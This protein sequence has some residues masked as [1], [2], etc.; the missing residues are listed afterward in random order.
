MRRLMVFSCLCAM[1]VMLLP[2]APAT[3]Q[4]QPGAFTP[5]DCFTELPAGMTTDDVRCGLVTVPLEH[6]D[7]EGE[8]I[9][10]AVVVVEATGSSPAADP[11]LMLGGG[12][13]EK[14]IAAFP[15]L[16]GEGTPFA[17]ILGERDIVL[18]DQRGVGFSQPALD[19]PEVPA[20]LMEMSGDP[21][22]TFIEAVGECHDRLVSEGANLSAFDTGN[23]VADI[24]LVREALGYETWN[25]F[26]NSYGA[27]LA[28]KAAAANE[29]TIRAQVL[30]S[31]I[32]GDANFLEDA[33]DS[34]ATA[35]ERLY[36]ACAASESCADSFGDIEADVVSVLERLRDEP[37]TLEVVDP[38]T[39]RTL[40]VPLTAGDVAASLFQVFYAAPFLPYLPALVDALE[41]GEYE[42]LLLFSMQ[43]EAIP[44]P[45]SQGMQFSFIC[46]E[47][48]AYTSPEALQ[49]RTPDDSLA[50]ELLVETNPVIGL[51]V[52][53]ICEAWDVE[54]ADESTFDPVAPDV[55][56]LIFSG[57]YDQITPPSYAAEVADSLED[58]VLVEVPDS[59]HSPAF[60]LGECGFT[61]LADYLANP[62]GTPETGCA[63][64]RTLEFQSQLPAVV[65]P[66]GTLDACPPDAVPDGGFTDV[67]GTNVHE[68]A[69]RCMRWWEL[70]NGVTDTEYRPQAEV[71]RAQMA[72]FIARLIEQAGGTLEDV[73]PHDP[74]FPDIADSVHAER[75]AQL[76]DIG[77]VQGRA[78]GTYAPH[79]FVNRAQMAAFLVR[80]VEYVTGE[81]LSGAD[82]DYFGDDNGSTHEDAIDKA[83][84]AGLTGGR[85]NGT[86]APA[87]ST[88]RDQTASFLARAADL[89][90]EEDVA[91]LP[92]G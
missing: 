38:A 87:H 7:P 17:S 33:G 23:N 85:A 28:L 51:P 4:A 68:F 64:S 9:E 1:L 36:D 60:S 19:C 89:L 22:A 69:V 42:R 2:A 46:A 32:P 58:E 59:G 76:A 66:R 72:S 35:L 37:A 18:L 10:V 79:G 84:D 13:G 82:R 12:P 80:A 8:T 53:E 62:S 44:T 77:V 61:I 86:Y 27:R 29:D 14:L 43:Q 63:T 3:A 15:L 47:E 65:V 50:A 92:E 91:S 54:T 75:I 45:I 34:F 40:G 78:D 11:V 21:L 83:A 20:N 24:D 25:V 30:S 88:R 49:D 31:S 16:F 52:F 73:D 41:A 71:T 57:D 5:T 56:T 90:V 74:A 67:P 48:V 81:E 55:P 70:T 39:G 6:A 26:G